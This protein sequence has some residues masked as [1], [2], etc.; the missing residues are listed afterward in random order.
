MLCF[1]SL[2]DPFNRRAREEEF[3][4]KATRRLSEILYVECHDGI[5][6]PVN[7]GFEDHLVIRV[8]KRCSARLQVDSYSTASGTLNNNSARPS[9]TN[10]RIAAEAPV[11]LRMPAPRF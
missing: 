5:R 11:G 10:R 1:L 7:G 9:R 8:A 2:P 6:L 4:P 3:D